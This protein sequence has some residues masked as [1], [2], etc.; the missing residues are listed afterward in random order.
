MIDNATNAASAESLDLISVLNPEWKEKCEE[1][2]NR[3]FKIGGVQRA[4]E[5]LFVADF[6][7]RHDLALVW[8]NGVFELNPKR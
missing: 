8:R 6:A 7:A 2:A 5:I 1:Y 3:C 4:E